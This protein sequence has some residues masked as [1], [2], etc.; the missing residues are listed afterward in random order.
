ME[1]KH[2]ATALFISYRRVPDLATSGRLF[3]T[4]DILLPEAKIFMD[5]ESL[6]AGRNFAEEI[7][8]RL[9]EC[10][11]LLLVI[12]P[13][14]LGITDAK[15]IRRLDKPDDMVRTEIEFALRHGKQI[16][17]VL[18]GNA[19]M[20]SPERLP[21]SIAPVSK[22]NAVAV[23][24][25][26]FRRDCEQ[27][28]EKIKPALSSATSRSIRTELSAFSSETF[29]AQ[30]LVAERPPGWEFLLTA[31]LWKEALSAPLRRLCDIVSGAYSIPKTSFLDDDASI[32]WIRDQVGTAAGM[33]EPLKKIMEVEFVRAC[34]EPGVA[35]DPQEILHVSR[36][37]KR[38]AEIIVSWEEAVRSCRVSDKAQPLYKLLPGMAARQIEKLRDVPIKL[39]NDVECALT[40]LSRNHEIRIAVVFDLPDGWAEKFEREI[41][42]FDGT[43]PWYKELFAP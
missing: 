36:L 9:G 2:G 37:L 40:D 16:V 3:D 25:E 23:K 21:Q 15:G 17:P 1:F 28:A 11:V 38:A 34:G 12:S 8:A 29:E 14:W 13:D 22:C 35:G 5:V 4:L 32:V 18:I 30:R 7:S 41:R 19:T 33:I 43:L 26:N 31:E 27:L 10:Q 20:P 6:P 24:H 39:K 42:R